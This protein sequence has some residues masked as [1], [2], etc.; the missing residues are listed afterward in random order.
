MCCDEVVRRGRGHGD[1][2]ADGL[3]PVTKETNE[4]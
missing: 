3:D 1:P 4:R 2:G